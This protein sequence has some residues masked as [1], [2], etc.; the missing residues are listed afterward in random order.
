[1]LLNKDQILNAEDIKYAEVDC[2]PEWSGSVKVKA[3]SG[4]ERDSFERNHQL[5]KLT[6]YRATVSARAI[7]DENGD[8]LFSEA[9]IIK[10]S[11]KSAVPLN[12]IYEKVMEISGVTEEEID[13]LE[14][15]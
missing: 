8:R 5:G 14:K 6:H 15:L 3:M 12:K 7:V 13:E 2:T 10:L 1:M 11:E 9:E 4:I